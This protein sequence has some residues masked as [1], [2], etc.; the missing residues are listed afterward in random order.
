MIDIVLFQNPI[1]HTAYDHKHNIYK[2]IQ[3]IKHIH[4]YEWEKVY[5]TYN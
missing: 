3:R 4:E 2:Y 5:C 1:S